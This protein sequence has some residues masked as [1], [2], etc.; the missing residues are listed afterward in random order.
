MK[1]S[2]SRRYTVLSKSAPMPAR[3]PKWA[4]EHKNA[5]SRAQTRGAKMPARVPKCAPER[6]NAGPRIQTRA[7]AP[8]CPPMCPN[9]MAFYYNKIRWQTDRRTELK[10]YEVAE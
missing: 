8:K 1:T 7:W 6:Q 5:R 10:E 4:P 2:V 3:V 9:V